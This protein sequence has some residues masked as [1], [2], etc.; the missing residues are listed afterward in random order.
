MEEQWVWFQ[1]RFFPSPEA[2]RDAPGAS[3]LLQGTSVLFLFSFLL[4]SSTVPG[5][6]PCA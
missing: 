6:Q 4:V 3:E 5:K 1:L 2:L